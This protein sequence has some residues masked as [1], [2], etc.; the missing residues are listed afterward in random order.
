MEQ[1]P[2][3]WPICPTF[4]SLRNFAYKGIPSDNNEQGKRIYSPNEVGIFSSDELRGFLADA[5]DHKDIKNPLSLFQV[6][7]KDFEY[8]QIGNRIKEVVLID[9]YVKAIL[10]ERRIIRIDPDNLYS[11]FSCCDLF[12]KCN[13][14]RNRDLCFQSDSR[15]GLLYDSRLS[16]VNSNFETFY[17]I[18][19]TI[20]EE[21][22]MTIEEEE[23]QLKLCI[24]ENNRFYIRY[25]CKYSQLYE[26]FFPIFYQGK[27]LAI[28]MQGQRFN[29][30]LEREN[31]F[32]GYIEHSK[33]GQKLQ[34]AINQIGKKRFEEEPMSEKRLKAII[35]RI[36]S[37]ERRVS[38]EMNA[39]AQW[40]IS[41]C[42]SSWRREFRN[43]INSIDSNSGNALA[44][45]KQALD[46]T[47]QEICEVFNK[48]GFIRIYSRVSPMDETNPNLITFELIGDSSSNK[49]LSNNRLQFKSV[50]DKEKGIVEKD[51]LLQYI[52][53]QP[54][55]FM[56][57]IDF[58]RLEADISSKKAYIIWKR[59]NSNINNTHF[60]MYGESL[61]AIYPTFLK[62]YFMLS[63]LQ[64]EQKLEASMR[65]SVHESAQIIPT[66]ID[67]INN[68]ETLEILR[69]GKSYNASSKIELPIN[70]VLNASNRLLL[71][72]ELFRR[73]TLIFK[74]ELPK[75][76]WH[77]L[78]RIIYSAKSLFE[79]KVFV[80]N[81]QTLVIDKNMSFSSYQ[82]YTDDSYMSQ[83]LFNLLDNAIKYGLR[84]SQI[85][86]NITLNKNPVL[87]NVLNKNCIRNIQ[88]SIISYGDKISEETLEHMYDLYYRASTQN[89]EGMGLGL[90]LVKKL[91]NLMDYTIECKSVEEC[92]INV[93]LHYFY[94]QQNNMEN[95][96]LEEPYKSLLKR[97]LS[98]DIINKVVNYRCRGYWE[99]TDEEFKA[100]IERPTY[101][102]EFVI[103]IPTD[104]NN[105][106]TRL[107]EKKNF[108]N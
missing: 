19:K 60:E 46:N 29:K 39:A 106:K 24:Y 62:S 80:Q 9:K 73:P 83:I 70:K 43:R 69:T 93:P 97:S 35:G 58:F 57:D 71:L 102:N 44:D 77:D 41:D 47:L 34:R 101:K 33:A 104:T 108:N 89:V 65:I 17:S 86:F 37:L 82:L 90:F 59:Y 68:N 25:K 50:L 14:N 54:V 4:L 7:P 105:L 20:I 22:N 81:M 5:S 100:L 32:K 103:T 98:N 61:K 88:I 49:K 1:Q 48:D 40:Y 91:C 53:N 23:F 45:Y 94:L 95:T 12:R 64:S 66:V 85:I 51:I 3:F 76:G 8:K 15:I 16:E 75:K 30:K 28:L 79:N 78:H 56:R 10:G 74:K 92:D 67:A 6:V 96:S 84:G 27:V 42:F 21:Y 55:G 63:S 38:N 13:R 52:I 2:N 87:K 31:L 72:E 18:L 36:R 99:V 26:Y 107:Y 11:N